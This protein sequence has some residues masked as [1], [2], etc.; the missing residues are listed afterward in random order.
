MEQL[1]QILS[2]YFQRLSADHKVAGQTGNATAELS[3]RPALDSFLVEISKFINKDIDRI[4]EPRTQ[5]KSGRPDWLFSNK[6][7]MGIYGYIEAKGFNPNVALNAKDYESQVN[8]YLYL[9]NP[10]ILTDGIDF[11]IYNPSG[12]VETVSI[13]PKPINWEN[14][15]LNTDIYLHLKTFFKEEGYRTISEKQLVSE[16]S[17]RAKHLSSEL[18]EIISLEE[19]EAENESE[20]QTVIAL[21]Q[22]W[23]IASKSHDKSLKDDR[24]FS[25]FIAQILAFGLLYAHRFV[26]NKKASPVDKYNGLNAFWESEKYKQVVQRVSPFKMLFEALSTEL[27]SPFSKIGIWYDNTRRLLSCIHLTTKQVTAPNFHELYE[28]FLKDYDGKTRNDFGAWYTPM[29][30]ADYTAKFVYQVLPSIIPGDTINGKAIKIIDPCCGTGTF[31]ESVANHIPLHADSQIIGFEILPVPYALANYRISTLALKDDIDIEIVLTNTLSDCTFLPMK[32][33]GGSRDLVSTLFRKEQTKALSLSTPPLTVVIGNPPCSDAINVCNE[34]KNI[35]RLM[36]DF[37]PNIR[38]GR[39]NV[40]KQLANEMTK[41]LRWCLYKAELSRPSVFALVLP[42]SF[43]NNI[44]YTYVRKYL[45]EKVSEMWILEFD[46]D[47]RAGHKAENLF[48]TLQGRLLLV[49]TLRELEFSLPK[50]HYKSITNLSRAKKENFFLSTVDTSDWESLT[51]D[52]DYTFKPSV[53]VN[54]E[55]YSKFWYLAS[56]EAPAIFKHHC[57]GLKLAP[58]HLLV[59]FDK[60]VMKRRNKFIANEANTYEDIKEKWYKGQAKP[61]VKNKITSAVRACICDS[62]S[63]IVKYSYRPFLTANLLLGKKLMT[64][65]RQTE[66]GGMRERPEIQ[67]AFSQDGVFGFA[68]APAPADISPSIKKFTSFCW[69]LP[70][71]DLATRGNSHVFCNYFPTAQ[72]ESNWSKDKGNN[73]NTTLLSLMARHFSMSEVDITNDIIFYSYALLNSDLFLHRFEGKLYRTAGRWPAIPITSD[74]SL[75]QKVTSIGRMMADIEKEDYIP[76]KDIMSSVYINGDIPS[77]FLIAKYS[78]NGDIISIIG[79]QSN[80]LF[81]LT[82]PKGMTDYQVS[83]YS[84]IEQWLKYHSYAYY[85]KSCSKIELDDLLCLIKKINYFKLLVDDVD[86]LVEQILASGLISPQ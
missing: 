51:L 69:H 71:N 1:K 41:F 57:S 78:I 66:G 7:S 20:K 18:Q 65:L 76:A 45:T 36:E 72:S 82:L 59:H 4:F 50:I 43:A 13:C 6:E 48:N 74:L 15:Q 28:A 30:L 81:T 77:E 68:V 44:S 16:L 24:M 2:N 39:S 46:I 5:G 73:V 86:L 22:L 23:D 62:D 14:P 37:R 32:V 58:T 75:F 56:D 26:N 55:L 40:Q 12:T 85:R 21:K 61:P 52:Q 17:T 8:R 35:A 10:V 64:A 53:N 34:G 79:E 83:G 11:I 54:E 47:N 63:S 38:K 27:S 84:V 31:I 42:S 70:D 60:G 3:Y 33:E 29:C 25:G 80:T 67:M 19:D 49:G 9:G